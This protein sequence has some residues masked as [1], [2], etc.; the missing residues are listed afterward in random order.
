M[1][2]TLTDQRLARSNLDDVAIDQSVSQSKNS[3][4]R[5]IT[6]CVPSENS[7]DSGNPH[8]FL[9]TGADAHVMPKFVWE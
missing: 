4:G 3:L 9:D 6:W 1:Q 2:I 8:G 7:G 5:L